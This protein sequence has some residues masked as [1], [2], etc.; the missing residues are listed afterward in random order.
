MKYKYKAILQADKNKD[1][2]FALTIYRKVSRRLAYFFVNCLKVY[3][4]NFITLLSLVVGITFLVCAISNYQPVTKLFF[5]SLLYCVYF[6]IDCTDGIVARVVGNTSE[7]GKKL[8]AFVDGRVE[9]LFF[10]SL[11]LI[12]EN[13]LII[14]LWVVRKIDKI[15]I[16]RRKSSFYK[17]LFD[18]F[19][20]KINKNTDFHIHTPD[21]E[22]TIFMIFAVI[23]LIQNNQKVV[24]Y[25]WVIY[26]TISFIGNIVFSLTSNKQHK[27]ELLL[28]IIS[29]LLS[30]L[31]WKS[32]LQSESYFFHD[33]LF[34][35]DNVSLWLNQHYPLWGRIVST[36][37][38][39]NT[40]RLSRYLLI[41]VYSR[42]LSNFELFLKLWFFTETALALILNY[43]T[44]KELLRFFRKNK[45]ISTGDSVLCYLISISYTLS[46]WTIYTMTG[47]ALFTGWIVFPGV[48]YFALK[49]HRAN[50][51][52]EVI[53]YSIFFSLF[54][55]F[56]LIEQHA[57][58]YAFS[59][60]ITFILLSNGGIKKIFI[61]SIFFAFTNIHWIYPAI[62]HMGEVSI[63]LPYN[64]V[65][66]ESLELL[67]RN[68]NIQTL[69]TF[70]DPWKHFSAI[71]YFF[72]NTV[73]YVILNAQLFVILSVLVF[74]FYRMY[75][76]RRTDKETKSIILTSFFVILL[77]LV[78][79]G[80][81]N[82]LPSL[83][84][85]ATSLPFFGWIFRVPYRVEMLFFPLTL[86][87]LTYTIARNKKIGTLF[88]IF[89]LI[90]N[91]AFMIPWNHLYLEDF[92][93]NSPKG[94]EFTL[95][96]IMLNNSM[97]PARVFVITPYY[98]EM[99]DV[100]WKMNLNYE[101]L[102]QI[103]R[104]YPVLSSPLPTYDTVCMNN[105]GKM[106]MNWFLF[107]PIG[108]NEK[109]WLFEELGI[110][111]YLIR[112][113]VLFKSR[114]MEE[115]ILSYI[116]YLNKTNECSML[117]NEYNILFL[118]NSTTS[119]IKIKNNV[120]LSTDLLHLM[121][122]KDSFVFLNNY[123]PQYYQMLKNQPV[124]LEDSPD[125]CLFLSLLEGK[126]PLII[127]PAIFT[128]HRN[129]RN[130]WSYANEFYSSLTFSKPAI[131]LQN[132]TVWTGDFGYGIAYTWAKN[133]TL[134]MSFS[135]DKSKNYKLLIRYFRNQQGDE[136]RV[137]LDGEPILIKTKDQLN[138]FVWSDIGD[139]YLEK[140]GHEVVLEN[141]N[142]F[143]AVNLFAL[144]TSEEVTETKEKI[145]NLLQDKR[146]IYILEAESDLHHENTTT[147]NKYGG[148]ASNGQILILNQTSAIW[149]NVT[150]AKTDN[151]RLAIRSK[152]PL[153]IQIDNQTYTTNSTTLNW[154]HL[155]TTNL[156]K[157]DY[158]IQITTPNNAELD[159][160]WL[161]S[162]QNPNETLQDVFR[163]KQKAAEITNYTKIGPTKYTVNINAT[164]PFMLSF[165]EAY[166]PL[167][168]CYVNGEK[169]SS[170]PLYGVING[171]WVNQTGQLDIIIEYEPQKWFDYGLI[172]S[173]TTFLACLTYLTY[174]WTKNKAILKRTK[175]ILTHV[176]LILH[177]NQRKKNMQRGK[178]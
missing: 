89:I 90:T 45:K 4:P 14:V 1:G 38:L 65:T 129:G 64:V 176:R 40:I 134:R 148:E 96:S 87:L 16:E 30:F 66:K 42:F 23:S 55:F 62:V 5:L 117:T 24:L 172:I 105:F 69:F 58:L 112:K 130:F 53:K 17:N 19:F 10:L 136:I 49:L 48:L 103:P 158:K 77:S 3:N 161:Y 54:S 67:S 63:L 140:G 97:Q 94:E 109:K 46:F 74:S 156:N 39:H 143:N 155:N 91:T 167:W 8:D 106:L 78:I 12:F 137:Y 93:Q 52:E 60:L 107:L 56:F 101:D 102:Y 150:I 85:A 99:Q 145:A 88:L 128:K 115:N 120:F 170:I 116:E 159:V 123:N 27:I 151:Y 43:C 15:I 111:A 138:K 135:I 146:I 100:S 169:V 68:A 29:L 121:S 79:K 18:K 7:F 152:G 37:N 70:Y 153:Q 154:N 33:D 22:T 141:I 133:A 35:M 20:K 34:H 160:I 118:C 125:D 108:Y 119:P 132:T 178:V 126:E 110:N 113:D 28:S 82:F 9:D 92:L 147:S 81:T 71:K 32:L 166:D 124:I 31:F 163:T 164:Q 6:S 61:F 174:N 75:K 165:A 59:L 47:H 36:N 57:M 83:Y 144:I 72:G 175:S 26:V 76:E 95:S 25:S 171:F 104:Y 139:F 13:P 162:T 80:G 122:I 127:K 157:G 86:L 149:Q 98:Y 177:L 2:F 173:V 21:L 131:L 41:F 11:F 114:V 168:A 51:F 50:A 73:F 142:G 44:F 84:E